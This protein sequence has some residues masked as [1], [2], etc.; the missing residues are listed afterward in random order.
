MSSRYEQA[1]ILRDEN[2]KR[3]SNTVII[4]APDV[5]VSADIFLEITS[6]ERLDLLA[7]QFYGDASLWWIIASANGLGKGTLYTPEGIILRIPPAQ[8]IQNIIETINN[9]R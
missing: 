8:N 4:G 5:N 2:G 1:K 9:E 3:K 6:P 7:N